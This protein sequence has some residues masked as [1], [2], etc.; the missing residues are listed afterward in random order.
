MK[1]RQPT[2]IV[3][4]PAQGSYKRSRLIIY[5]KNVVKDFTY[6]IKKVSIFFANTNSIILLLYVLI[7][8]WNFP[9]KKIY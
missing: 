3:E 5:F 8:I 9:F 2:Q 4:V 6:T 7:A 1:T